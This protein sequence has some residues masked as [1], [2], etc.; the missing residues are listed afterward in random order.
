MPE[1]QKYIHEYAGVYFE[2][3]YE[4]NE[5]PGVGLHSVFTLNADMQPTGPD[6]L[7]W[8]RYMTPITQDSVTMNTSYLDFIA[9]EILNE[10]TRC[11][12]SQGVS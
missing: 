4:I 6:L 11:D 5:T 3:S 12:A 9:Q 10:R 1:V 2:V 8:L 7:D